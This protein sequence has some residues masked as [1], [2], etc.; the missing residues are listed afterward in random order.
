MEGIMWKVNGYRYQLSHFTT[1]LLLLF[2]CNCL[3]AQN[4][5][6]E[7]FDKVSRSVVKVKNLSTNCAASGFIWN[8][9]DRIVTSLH[10]VDKGNS[11]SVYY[12]GAG[13]TRTAIVEKILTD[14]D[15]ALLKVDNAPQMPILNISRVAPDIGDEIYALGF[16]VNAPKVNSIIL[17]VKYGGRCLRDNVDEKIIRKIEQNGYPSVDMEVANFEGNLVPGTSG[18]PIVNST[19]DVVAIA[20]GGLEKGAIGICWGIPARNLN[21]LHNSVSQRLPESSRVQE[22]F[23][24]ELNANIGE[25]IRGQNAELTKERTRSFLQIASSADDQLGLSQ[26]SAVLGFDQPNFIFDIYQDFTS[27]ATVVVPQGANIQQDEG[28][29]LLTFNNDRFE[30]HMQ[31]IRVSSMQELNAKSILFE[32]SIASLQQTYQWQIDRSFSYQFLQ[33]RFDGMMVNRKAATG[34]IYNQVYNTFLQDK[35]LF[36]TLAARNNLLIAYVAIN[37]DVTLQT[38]QAEQFCFQ[39][40]SHE[41]CPQLFADRR[42]WAQMVLAVH[43]TNFSLN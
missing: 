9:S 21:N 37:K 38:L 41:R 31:L 25:T 43:L 39:G 14:A 29:W 3:Q 27:G 33:T 15:L 26:L 11:Y 32:Q 18:A 6:H 30:M 7:L 13:V 16:G 2:L 22:L 8:S 17:R 36:E 1:I 42:L 12:Q 4:R 40:G 28:K 20:D 34:Y 35:Y 23:G 19:G 24:V 5:L 10:V